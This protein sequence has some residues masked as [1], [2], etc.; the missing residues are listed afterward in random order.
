MS[1]YNTG[2]DGLRTEQG[3]LEALGGP[4]RFY[5]KAEEERTFVFID[6]EPITIYEHNPRINGSWRNWVTCVQGAHSETVCCDILGSKHKRYFVGMYTVMDITGWTDKQN[7]LHANNVMLLPAK[8]KSL[9][10]LERKAKARGG[11]LQGCVFTAFRP[12]KKSATIGD[13]FEFVKMMTPEEIFAVANYKSKPL[14]E[15]YEKAQN[16][17]ES[18]QRLQRLFSIEVGSGGVVEPIPVPFNYMEVLA[19]LEVAQLREM[20]AGVQNDGGY[21][22]NSGGGNSAGAGASAGAPAGGSYAKVED[23][24]F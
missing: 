17:G 8:F 1:W 24:P 15:L 6:G 9:K 3:R 13:D 14:R 10:K 2:Y 19:P 22:G 16:D 5:I 21:G 11:S 7:N 18:M 12:D 4:D 23:V 20:L